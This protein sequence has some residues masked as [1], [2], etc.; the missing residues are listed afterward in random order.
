VKTRVNNGFLP[1]QQRLLYREK[2]FSG[3]QIC[4]KKEP[5]TA[6]VNDSFDL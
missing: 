4:K 5:F 1:I 2:W 3:K 6:N